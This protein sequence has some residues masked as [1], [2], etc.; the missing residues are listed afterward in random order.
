M[1]GRLFRVAALVVAVFLFASPLARAQL[2][3]PAPP[4]DALAAARELVTTM[5]MVDQFKALLPMIMKNLKPAIVQNRSDIER[6]YDAMTPILLDGFQARVGELSE[7]VAIIYASNFS[8]E[9]LQTLTA[10]YKTPTGQKFLQKTPGVAA[11]TMAAG[12]K[13]GQSVATELRQR[14]TDELRKKGHDL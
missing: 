2:A 8:A 6:D 3:A 13:F 7:A 12:Q 4:P 10:F 9:D 5:H 11:Q 14:M 1:S